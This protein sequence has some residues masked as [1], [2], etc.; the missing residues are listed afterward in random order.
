MTG[1]PAVIRAGDGPE[2]AWKNGGGTTR[3]IA[4]FPPGAAMDDFLWRL[5]LATIARPGPFS[6]FPGMRRVLTVIDGVLSL[7]GPDTR[8]RLTRTSAPF[9]FDG[10]EPIEGVPVG[11]PALALNAIT[12]R[13]GCTAHVARLGPGDV[14]P[15]SGLLLAAEPQRF[16]P[17]SMARLDC[18]RLERAMPV[19]GAAVAVS[20]AAV[21][22]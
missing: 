3:E 21:G 12:R 7:T 5:S 1:T 16:G 9:A 20:F 13:A 17:I 14:S 6:L 22:P 10:A 15:A 19:A 18:A 8:V 2:I 4:V 11:G